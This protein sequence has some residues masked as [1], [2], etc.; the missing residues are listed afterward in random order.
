MLKLNE[1][2]DPNGDEDLER[3]L[4]SIEKLENTIGN[5]NHYVDDL[6]SHLEGFMIEDPALSEFGSMEEYY[7]HKEMPPISDAEVRAMNVDELLKDLSKPN[8]Q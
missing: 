2:E 6:K 5:F 7:R 8:G 1:K 3:I 4:H